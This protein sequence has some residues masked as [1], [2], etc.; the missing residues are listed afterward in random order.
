M[1]AL[2]MPDLSVLVMSPGESSQEQANARGHLFER[3]VARLLNR[4]GFEEPRTSNLNNTAEGIELDVVA[5]HN[6]THAKAIAE[7]KAYSRPVRATELTSFY[8]KLAADRL[9]EPETFGLMV[10]LPR[11][12]PEGE[13]KA[14][15]ISARDSK[16]R[17]LNADD[18]A[19]AMRELGMVVDEPSGL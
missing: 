6:L 17:Y 8:G 12:T 4:Y 7:C 9:V 11:L 14:R 13:E 2:A 16:F 10:T 15:S 3:F 18:V 5:R 1:T 19:S